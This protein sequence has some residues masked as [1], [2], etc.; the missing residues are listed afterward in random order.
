MSRTINES[1]NQLKTSLSDIKTSLSNKNIQGGEQLKV[2]EVAGLIDQIQ[3]GGGEPDYSD[4][5]QK[6]FCLVIIKGSL[7]INDASAEISS[8]QYG[9]SGNLT[10]NIPTDS[11][12]T[13]PIFSSNYYIV[14]AQTKWKNIKITEFQ[15]EYNRYRLS[16]EI[17]VSKQGIQIVEI[18]KV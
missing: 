13:F 14:V 1:V 8:A 2:S 3:S 6:G 12:H 5:M 18:K 16:E 7:N 11:I 9:E 4:Y 10:N 17:D 15:S